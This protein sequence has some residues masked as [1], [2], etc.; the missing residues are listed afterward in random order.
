[1]GKDAAKALSES[2]RYS[3]HDLADKPDI[4]RACD[5]IREGYYKYGVGI[6]PLSKTRCYFDRSAAY[7]A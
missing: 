4:G 7:I 5:D 1:M 6:A 3:L 2:T